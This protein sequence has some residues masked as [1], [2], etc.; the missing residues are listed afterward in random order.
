MI[1]RLDHVGVV[2]HAWGEASDVLVERL[3]FP[4]ELSR[5]QMPEGNL[6]EPQNTR[7]Y[8]VKVGL[9]VTLIEI[10]I[11]QD[12]ESG[13][14]RYLAKRGPGLHHL[15]YAC[16]DV[17]DEARRLREQGLDQI[18]IGSGLSGVFFYPRSTMGILMEL[19]TDRE[20]TA[21]AS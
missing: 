11:P 21:V 9:G 15:G 5:T 17:P 19:V 2:A 7:I 14:A 20:A 16:D 4:L 10:L 12:T 8:F 6:Y 1:I 13:I 3:G 18:A